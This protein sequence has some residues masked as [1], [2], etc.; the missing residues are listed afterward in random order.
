MALKNTEKIAAGAVRQGLR[1]WLASQ[2]AGI[3]ERLTRVEDASTASKSAWRMAFGA[4]NARLDDLRNS[5]EIHER[6]ARLEAERDL[7]SETSS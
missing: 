7:K 3:S 1:A 6:L 5:L 4:I 2:F